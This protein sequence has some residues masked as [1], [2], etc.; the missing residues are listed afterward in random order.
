MA[1]RTDVTLTLPME[2]LDTLSAVIQTGLQHTKI[3]AEVRR[4]LDAWWQAEHD[5]IQSELELSDG[6]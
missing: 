5:L 2:Y 4:E 6:E 1:K 3:K